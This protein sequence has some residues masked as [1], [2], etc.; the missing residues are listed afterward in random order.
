MREDTAGEAAL[1]EVLERM[2]LRVQRVLVRLLHRWPG[3]VA[4]R[5]AASCI[6]IEVFDRSMTI[7]AQFFTSVFPILILLA[8]ILGAADS[9]AIAD[10]VDMPDES[11]EVLDEALEQ[12]GGS[13]FG[14][15]GALIVLASATSLSRALTRAFAAIWLLPR[16]KSSL[17]SAW[18]WLAVVVSLALSLVVVRALSQYAAAVPP[19]GVWQRVV[20]LCLD[21]AIMVLVPWLLLSGAVGLRR[22]VPGALLF[23]AVMLAVRPASALWLPRAL[24]VSAERY[25]SIGVAFT[26]LAW[27]YVVAFCVLVTAVLG[28]VLAMDPGWLGRRIRGDREQEE[29][30]VEVA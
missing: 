22:L 15:V 28:Q 2:P 24:D 16:P 19:S 12:A 10:A 9:G 13:T 17:R 11:R 18:R 7:A 1:A 4:L 30:R 8:S 6:R 21:T 23:A 29:A 25:G 27:L 14:V 20:A 5:S 3:R 26:Y